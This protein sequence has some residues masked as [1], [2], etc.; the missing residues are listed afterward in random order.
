MFIPQFFYLFIQRPHLGCFHLLAIVNNTAVN[1]SVQISLQDPRSVLWV[2][3][4]C[5]TAG[6]YVNSC[7]NFLRNRHTVV[8]RGCTTLNTGSFNQ[9]LP[10]T[11]MPL[12]SLRMPLGLKKVERKMARSPLG[13]HFQDALARPRPLRH[14]SCVQCT[15][16]AGQQA[17]GCHL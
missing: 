4:R 17:P 13:P 5:G 11:W 8:H 6:S 7:F 1:M 14:V 3:A 15:L 9:M 10:D 12:A 16:A 2:Y